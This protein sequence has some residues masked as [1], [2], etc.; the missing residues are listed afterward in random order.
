MALKR[1]KPALKI[2]LYIESERDTAP[3][4][5][6]TADFLRER[7]I[8]VKAGSTHAK[9]FAIDSDRLFLGSTNLTN[10]SLRFNNETNV[11]LKDA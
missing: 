2:R 10:Q 3:R 8:E 6:Q 5:Q 1:Q 11:L 4:N 9:G 7:G